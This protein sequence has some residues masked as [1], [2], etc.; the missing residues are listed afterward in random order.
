MTYLQKEYKIVFDKVCLGQVTP[1]LGRIYKLAN[2]NMDRNDESKNQANDN[3][4]LSNQSRGRKLRYSTIPII[5]AVLFII[6][7]AIVNASGISGFISS[8]LSVLTPVILGFS[9]AYLLNYILRTIEFKIFKNMRPSVGKRVL[10]L[11]LTYLFTLLVIVAIL[12]LIIPQLLDS[13]SL[14]SSNFDYY[15]ES[16]I[17]LINDAIASFLGSHSVSPQISEKDLLAAVSNFFNTSSDIFESVGNYLI[18][19]GAGFVVGV[20][21]VLIALFISI[22]I[23]ASKETLKAQANKFFTAFL[24]EDTKQR[25]YKYVRLC[26]RTF[27]G[28]FIGKIIDSLIIGAITLVTLILFDMPYEI[29][30][31]SIVCITNVIPVFGPFIGAIPSFFIIFIVDPGKA[32][33]FLILILIIQQ[34]D[35]NIIGPKILGNSTGLSSLGVII[36]ITIMGDYFGIIGMLLGVPIS[37]VAVMIIT[38]I[39]EDK[40]RRK[41]LPLNTAEYFQEEVFAGSNKPRRTVIYRIF[42]ATFHAIVKTCRKL[43]KK[44]EKKTD[45]GSAEPAQKIKREDTGNE[46]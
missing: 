19:Y 40:L 15:I 39:V 33:L 3:K 11:C 21:N 26:D 25:M 5:C 31:A 14:F 45:V 34:I 27:G 29:L 20:K 43:F 10:S 41:N 24:Q 2:D 1:Y 36:A 9:F 37:A 6:N 46:Q 23:L 32:F 35:G 42:S 28:F 38:E 22:Y 8:T 13:I 4:G 30:V 44:K 17:A 18:Q 7:Y 16:T 12:F